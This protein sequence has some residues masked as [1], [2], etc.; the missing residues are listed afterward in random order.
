MSNNQ[1][2]TFLLRIPIFGKLIRSVFRTVRHRI[3]PFTG[4]RQYWEQRYSSG[5]NSGPGSYN[6]LAQY[7]AEVLNA[8]V[9]E[10]H[11][12]SVIEF[13]CG[14]GSQL[15]LAN[16]PSYIGFD[17][18]PTAV[19]L[20][21][22]KFKNDPSK[23]FKLVTEYNGEKAELTLSLDVIYHL[24]E[25]QVF[26]QYMAQLFNSAQRY[27]IIY[28]S[29]TNSNPIDQ[30]PYLKHREFTNWIN[31]N[32]PKWHLFNHLPN[33]YPYTGDANTGSFSDFYFF[34]DSTYGQLI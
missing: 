16:Y 21:Q 24:V 17:I 20:C 34:R 5:G 7:K 28:S 8:F 9:A 3:V 13:G 25:D 27:V 19:L 12:P 23:E 4:S 26:D 11:I 14:D 15:Q 22:E 33:R 31:I 6:K 10:N 32:S 29:N 2:K 18:S 1:L 30:A